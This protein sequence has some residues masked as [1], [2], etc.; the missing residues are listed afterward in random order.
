MRR[1]IIILS[2]GERQRRI[3][4]LILIKIGS[5]IGVLTWKAVKVSLAI[6]Q[7][8]RLRMLII[9]E[10]NMMET[11][12][13]IKIRNSKDYTDILSP[14][15]KQRILYGDSSTS[16]GHLSREVPERLLSRQIGHLKNC[17]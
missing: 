15:E 14:E 10:G 11:R 7:M 2:G 17:S 13:L 12:Y 4:A 6:N 1:L 16:G 3:P 5:G 9:R 8:E